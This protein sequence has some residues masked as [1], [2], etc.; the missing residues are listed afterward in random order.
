MTKKQEQTQ[1]VLGLAPF[2]YSNN[3]SL[4]RYDSTAATST[5]ITKTEERIELEA[6][7]QQLIQELQALK[8]RLGERAIGAIHRAGA[9]EYHGL[10]EHQKGIKQTFTGDEYDVYTDKFNHVNA[11]M[12]AQ[13]LREAMDAGVS[14]II[15]EI[16]R[17]LYVKEQERKGIFGR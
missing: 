11:Q 9:D 6:H 3:G 12:A 5:A 13:H 17:S 4:T 15:D 1:T 8:T 16:D 10:I 2:V 14:R 7:K